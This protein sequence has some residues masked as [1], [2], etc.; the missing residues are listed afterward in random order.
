MFDVGD[1]RGVLEEEV[2]NLAVHGMFRLHHKGWVVANL[3]QV[4]QSLVC[5][6]AYM[7]V[8]AGYKGLLENQLIHVTR[9]A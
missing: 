6:C 3:A 7:R 1:D 5:V 4:L 8:R 2:L 9:V